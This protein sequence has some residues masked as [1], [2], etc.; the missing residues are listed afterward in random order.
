MGGMDFVKHPTIWIATALLLAASSSHALPGVC[1]DKSAAYDGYKIVQ[2][3]V[4]NPI[5]FVTPWHSLSASL[6]KRLTLKVNAPFS[7]ESFEQ[8]SAFLSSTL[9]AD[10]ASSQQT[11]KLSYAGG[12]ILDC[13]PE[14]RT[15]RVVYPIF[16][17]VVQ[18]YIA[19]SLEQQ[20]GE[21]QRPA[22]TGATRASER[23]LL[24]APLAGYNRT[25]GTWG[26][27]TFSD[28]I[29]KLRLQGESEASGVSSSGHFDI[30]GNNGAVG[31]LWDHAEWAG[32]FEYVD[33]PAGA[34][35]FKE[36]KITG[37]FSAS[38]KEFAKKHV[39]VRYGA[40]L[41]GGHQQ[42][43][44]SVTAG[45]LLP[46]SGYGSLKLYVGATGRPGN[47][48]FTASYGLQ[49]GSTF[50]DAVPLFKKHLL[51]LGYNVNIP[52]PFRKPMGD[53]ED[54]KGPLSTTLHRSLNI[55]TRF[56]AGLIQDASG[57]PLAER[58][59]GG[60]A[61]RPFV[62]DSSWLILSDAFIRSI[63]ENQ[64]GAESGTALGGS[65]FYSANET[66]SFT[67]W[68]KPM[69]PKELATADPRFPGILNTPFHT[70][71]LS[72]ANTY[73]I[74]D[75]EYIRVSAAVSAKAVDLNKKLT[76]LS[77][78]LKLIPAAVVA[79]P[80]VTRSLKDIKR[81]LLSTRGA[82]S[83]IA[84]KPDP[85]VVDQLVTGLLPT[86]SGFIQSL[87]TELRDAAQTDLALQIDQSLND[88]NTL[89]SEIRDA[90]DLPSKKYDDQA[91]QTLAPGHRAIDVFLHELN[92]YSISPVAIFDVA[93]VWPVN[94]GVHYGVG[95]GL[96]LSL[97]NANFTISYGFNPQ[98][99]DRESIG[100]IFFK[101][102]VTSLF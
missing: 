44:D 38:T 84:S 64:L 92:I 86:L 99:S 63:P 11:L 27:L 74:K 98:R 12:E 62:Q 79:E 59:L 94:E 61:M 22:T 56:T 10:F 93:R 5:G 40:A 43:S 45:Q 46:N 71:A 30:A 68:G 57:T 65:R 75:P 80:T 39:I 95:P 67:I 87:T 3:D 100:A 60:N 82:A 25:L 50:M 17:S 7:L 34:A 53:A 88:V 83:M 85:Q 32:T 73:K 26:G 52:V 72:L 18:S 19:P 54:F 91:W 28:T 35:R 21:S 51:D 41:E 2:V 33:T 49:L 77:D 24:I 13:D 4:K 101:L 47:N 70:A 97:V 36:G 42:S 16:T 37:R 20:T 96:R 48:A 58:F 76:V 8:D 29:G 89:G 66:V 81:N 14:A 31:K 15:L 69:L 6:K 23:S 55:E 78:E 9:K 90:D 102:D 1:T